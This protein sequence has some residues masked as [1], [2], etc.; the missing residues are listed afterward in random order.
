MNELQDIRI[1]LWIAPSLVSMDPNSEA[2]LFEPLRA[3]KGARIFEVE[4]SWP[5]SERG[6]RMAD[7]PFQINRNSTL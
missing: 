4:V 3:V 5:A 2:K 1:Q 7:V 6:V